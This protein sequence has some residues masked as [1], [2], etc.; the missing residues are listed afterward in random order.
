MLSW[1]T[2]HPVRLH[3]CSGKFLWLFSCTNIKSKQVTTF[4]SSRRCRRNTFSRTGPPP[5]QGHSSSSV[6]AKVV[7][8]I[9]SDTFTL[10]VRHTCH[11]RSGSHSI[12]RP[13]S[14][15]SPNI[16]LLIPTKSASKLLDECHYDRRCWNAERNYTS[17]SC[18]FTYR[19][20]LMSLL[21]PMFQGYPKTWGSRR[22]SSVSQSICRP[23]FRSRQI[24]FDLC[25]SEAQTRQRQ[26]HPLC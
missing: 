22:R 16:Q 9:V 13:W 26:M 18:K 20:V 1:S 11:W 7:T 2:S 12:L 23:M 4:R 21:I 17:K 25:H 6:P 10:R 19:G 8:Y 14:W 5:S 15:Y 24:S 3:I